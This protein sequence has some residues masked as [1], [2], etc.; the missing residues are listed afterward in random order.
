L[1]RFSPKQKSSHSTEQV[2]LMNTNEQTPDTKIIRLTGRIV[3]AY[4]T[5]NR[6]DRL[7]VGE[8]VG[9][10]HRALSGL[11]GGEGADGGTDTSRPAVAVKRSVTADYIVCLEDGMRLKMLKRHL[12]THHNLTPQDYRAKWSLP[13]DY[14]MV[15]PNY[16]ERRSDLARAAGLGGGAS[17]AGKS[18]R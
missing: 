5:N 13:P 16:A 10:V 9:S 18:R 3:S 1:S 7:K 15:A 14:P 12:R 2:T 8:L 4:V 11:T 6:I 17:R